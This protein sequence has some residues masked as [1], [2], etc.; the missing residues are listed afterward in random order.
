[1]ILYCRLKVSIH[2]CACCNK[3]PYSPTPVYLVINRCSVAI[4][5]A[6]SCSRHSHYEDA[7]GRDF[8]IF[9][10]T[11]ALKFDGM[12]S[13]GFPYITC[14]KGYRLSR[15]MQNECDCF[16]EIGREYTVD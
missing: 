4:F 8:E 14:S 1:M 10:S 11:C 6:V 13:L 2:Y 9:Y 3:F 16:P 5:T 12:I 15:N 7:V